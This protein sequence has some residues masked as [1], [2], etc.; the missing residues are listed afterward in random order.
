MSISCV[1]G[2]STRCVSVWWAGHLMALSWTQQ[3]RH[4]PDMHAVLGGKRL[5]LGHRSAW[6]D[7]SRCEMKYC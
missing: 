2:T 1:S 7:K 5:H 6:K 3:S 4:R